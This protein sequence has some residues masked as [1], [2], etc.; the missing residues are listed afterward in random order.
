MFVVLAQFYQ[1]AHPSLAT[2]L[3]RVVSPS[4]RPTMNFLPSEFFT[5]L[6]HPNNPP[7]NA[8]MIILCNMTPGSRLGIL[9]TIKV[10]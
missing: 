10:S 8:K 2:R 7:S 3:E 4:A 6:L 9:L 1:S 5:F